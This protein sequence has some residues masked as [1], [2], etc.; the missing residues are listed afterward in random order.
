MLKFLNFFAKIFLS[1]VGEENELNQLFITI[2]A[3]GCLKQTLAHTTNDNFISDQALQPRTNDLAFNKKM[4]TK[5]TYVRCTKIHARLWSHSAQ[6]CKFSQ[7]PLTRIP[8]RE[9]L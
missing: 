3:N 9:M 4:R 5:T 7:I 2:L 8:I 6:N 1:Y